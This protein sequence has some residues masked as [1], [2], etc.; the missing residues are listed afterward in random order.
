MRVLSS[1]EL[2]GTLEVAVFRRHERPVIVRSTV[3]WSRRVGFD[4]YLAGLAFRD[5]SRAFLARLQ[6][7]LHEADAELRLAERVVMSS[8]PG[9]GGDSAHE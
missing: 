9:A 4:R 8:A 6:S 2:A 5:R 3:L 1:R 7:Y